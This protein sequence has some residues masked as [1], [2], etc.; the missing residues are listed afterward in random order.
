MDF[1]MIATVKKFN[2]RAPIVYYKNTRYTYSKKLYHLEYY[3]SSKLV[4]AARL[5]ITSVWLQISS[6]R[7]EFF[8]F[9]S[10]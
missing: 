10:S 1:K 7:M 6:H 2:V 9:K 4:V 3:L 8:K 5:T